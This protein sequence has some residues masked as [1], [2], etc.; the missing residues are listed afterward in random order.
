M[1]LKII[2]LLTLVPVLELYILIR[3]AEAW[4]LTEAVLLVIVTGVVGGWL[5]RREGVRAFKR[6][7][8]EANQ[9]HLPA[10]ALLDSVLIFIAGAFLVTPGVLTDVAGLCLLLPPTRALVR[11]RIKRWLKRKIEQGKINVVTG[12]QNDAGFHP[13]DKEPPPGSPPMED[14]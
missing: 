1:L 4:G 8:D 3:L 12:M 7:Q 5:A 10:D 9:G 6:V 14:E 13:I 11:V 2:L